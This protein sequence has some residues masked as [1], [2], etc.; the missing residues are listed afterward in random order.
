VTESLG[1]DSAADL[2][3]RALDANGVDYLF[4][5]AG[6]D[7]P[8][9]IEALAKAAEEGTAVPTAL[10]IPHENL[11]VAMAYGYALVSG[12]AQAVMMHVN[13]G[14]A[15]A[16]CGLINAS[17][18]RIPMLVAAGRTPYT[19][20]GHQASRNT[21][22]HWAQEMYDQAGMVREV[23]KWDYELTMPDQIVP[24]VHRALSLATTEP[25]GPVY[26]MLPREVLA[27]GVS[28]TTPQLKAPPSAWSPA[29]DPTAL[30]KA[31][32]ILCKAERP[33]I[34][35]AALGRNPSAVER[36]GDFAERFALPVVSYL[37][38][39]LCLPTDH[40]MH[41][42]Y[43]PA[44][45]LREADAV[46]VIECDVPWIPSRVSPRP[47]AKIIHLGVDP[48]FTRY[49]MR[50]FPCD[51][52]IT[53]S[54]RTALPMLGEAMASW[55]RD[56][57]PF[58]PRRE[59]LAARRAELKAEVARA[60]ERVRHDRPIHPLAVSEAIDAVKGEWDIVVSELGAPMLPLR[61]SHAGTFF[62]SSPAGGL[63]WGLGAALGA[64]LA[65]PNRLVIATVGDGSYMFGNPTPA[66]F[67]ARAYDIPVLFVVMNNA[68]WAAVRNATVAMY[69]QGRSLRVNRMP[70]ATL[71][72]S[73]D[74]EKVVEASGGY[75]E[76]V[77][78]P[79]ELAPA[80]ARA[81]HAVKVEKRQALLNVICSVR[82]PG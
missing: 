63:G 13:V 20:F 26:L 52:A 10:A 21:Y 5:N 2:F 31:A 7:F 18:A 79:E 29:A 53:A 71:E 37:P 24:A 46:L 80:L 4:A 78:T 40:P 75:G 33:L 48:L 65:A 9:I 30:A 22:I 54:P 35:T 32:E 34:I 69:P 74:F 64:K 47:G 55:M 17:R 82:G 44:A 70:L 43:D 50:S 62:A 27:A 81:I 58:E 51:L 14:T 66:H 77:E 61:F 49:P 45:L 60:C 1:G 72:P 25:K 23:V 68:G 28:T 41:F 38:T 42:G 8:P 15:N 57:R 12:R 73:P 6:T 76:R 36:L 56:D 3:L 39:S 11:A 19:E 59:H 67:V 16:V